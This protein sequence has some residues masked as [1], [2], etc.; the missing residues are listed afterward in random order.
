MWTYIGAHFVFWVGAWNQQCCIQMIMDSAP[1]A[2]E[3]RWEKERIEYYKRLEPNA[4]P[5]DVRAMWPQGTTLRNRLRFTGAD[6]DRIWD[7][8]YNKDNLKAIFEGWPAT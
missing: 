7:I 4:A 6:S 3:T 1:H 8:I 2:L 5:R